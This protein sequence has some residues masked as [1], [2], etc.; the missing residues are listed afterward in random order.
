MKII[1]IAGADRTGKS[2]LTQLFISNNWE[3]KHFCAPKIS[4]Y[5]EYRNYANWLITHKDLNKNYIIDRYMYCEFPYSKHYNR[6]TDMTIEKMHEIEDDLLKIDPNASII[7]CHTDL[8]SNWERIQAEGKNEFKNID[9]LNN[10]YNEYKK[11]LSYSKLNLITYNFTKG[12]TPAQI[13][14]LFK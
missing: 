5:T 10:L 11:I 1:V 12:D 14:N 6:Q 8:K 2:T 3:Y 7:Y 9:E 13:F 4:P